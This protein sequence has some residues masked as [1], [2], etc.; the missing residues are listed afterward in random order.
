MAV[1]PRAQTPNLQNVANPVLEREELLLWSFKSAPRQIVR[2]KARGELRSRKVASFGESSLARRAS[3]HNG[4]I[5]KAV[6]E[7]A[8]VAE[9]KSAYWKV[10]CEIRK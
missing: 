2:F 6:C 3:S 4:F 9:F 1:K 10:V 7:E 5:K 8:N